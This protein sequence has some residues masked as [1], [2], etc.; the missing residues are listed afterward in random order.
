MTPYRL[1][2]VWRACCLLRPAW[3]RATFCA[4]HLALARPGLQARLQPLLGC[5]HPGLDHRGHFAVEGKLRLPRPQALPFS[6][7]APC[8]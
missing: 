5:V 1:D 3:L 2:G 8:R 4:R 6:R 7:T